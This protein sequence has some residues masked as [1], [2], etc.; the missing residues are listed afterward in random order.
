MDLF[1]G[2][3]RMSGKRILLR[4]GAP[5]EMKRIARGRKTGLAFF[6][7]A[8]NIF[9]KTYVNPSLYRSPLG[10]E[11]DEVKGRSYE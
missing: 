1:D 10:E 8:C 6:G 5:V 2:G 9:R 11:R 4:L 3:H 7:K